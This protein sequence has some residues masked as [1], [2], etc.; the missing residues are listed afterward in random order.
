MKTVLGDIVGLE[1]AA[2]IQSRD[3]FDNSMLAHELAFK[4]NRN[5]F[6]PRCILKVD[7]QN[8][9]D[10][11]NWSFLTTCL[12][13]FGFPPSF[14]TGGDL[15]SIQAVD[16]CLALFSGYSGLK[17]NAMKSNL[18]FGGVNPQLKHLILTTTGYVE[19]DLP[20][21]YLGI[22]LFGARL[23]Q[24]LFVPLLDKLFLGY[25][26]FGELVFCCLKELLKK[27]NKMCKYFLWGIAD[28]NMRMVFKS[29]GSLCR[30]RMEGEVDIK[31]ILSWNKAQMMGWLQKHETNAPN[32]WV[33]WVNAYIVKGLR[34]KGPILSMHKTLGDTFNYAKHVIIG[35]LAVQNNLPMVD[36]VCRRGMM[37]VNRCVF[38]E[39]YSETIPH[40]FSECE[41]SAT[42]WQTVS[43]W[44]QIPF[45]TQLVQVLHWFKRHTRGKSWIKRQRRCLLL[46]TIYFLWNERNRR[47]FKDL[48]A[49]PSA[50][51]WKV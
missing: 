40:L 24:R 33:Q 28:G 8:T 22:P 16:K 21:R 29:W 35:L 41:Y 10:S 23:T 47:I 36:N 2:F 3:L 13:R 14:F 17:V 31:E 25:R 20:V 19:G 44:L 7:T 32:V 48:A 5:L 1:Q 38:C 50:I 46:C 4:Y 34:K 11:V 26:T 9:F 37:I 12:H 45:Q 30:P 6:T 42:V 39:N 49:P 51:V 15:P 43:Q 18:Y 27:V